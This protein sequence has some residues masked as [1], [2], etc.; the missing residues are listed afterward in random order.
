MFKNV[1]ECS[2]M[3]TVSMLVNQQ[4]QVGHEDGQDLHLHIQAFVSRAG[5][6]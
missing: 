3:L 6:H 2:R 4:A 1:Q 5:A